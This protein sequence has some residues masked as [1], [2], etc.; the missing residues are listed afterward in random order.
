MGHRL[1][2]LHLRKVFNKVPDAYADKIVGR[3]SDVEQGRK[4][5]SEYNEGGENRELGR[6]A[7]FRDETKRGVIKN[8]THHHEM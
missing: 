1:L 4:L 2:T 5:G 6:R 3:K 8:A 7:D